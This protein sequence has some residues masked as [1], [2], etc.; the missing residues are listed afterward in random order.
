VNPDIIKLL[1]KDCKTHGHGRKKWWAD[2]L[3]VPPLTVSHWLHGRQRP[4]GKHSLQIQT[5][6]ESAQ[7][8]NSR[9]VWKN[10][11]WDCYYGNQ[12]IPDN[13][14]SAQ[15]IEV[16]SLPA[17]DS[18]T[19]ALL[20]YY[21]ERNQLEFPLQESPELRNRLGWLLEVSGKETDIK[22]HAFRRPRPILVIAQSPALSKHLQSFQT[23]LGK[24]WKI[25]DCPLES[26]KSSFL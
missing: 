7:K 20:S 14:L 25:L 4:N 12:K 18:R 1:N 10:L 26:T 15:I 11:L 16:L 22:P 2:A 17:I 8:N 21:V 23:D 6:C 13:I 24:K 3:Q 5:I 9:T 19:L